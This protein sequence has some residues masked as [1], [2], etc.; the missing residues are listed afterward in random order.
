[1]KKIFVDAIKLGCDILHPKENLIESYSLTKPIKRNKKNVPL[2]MVV[3]P[4]RYYKNILK[5]TCL[6][7]INKTLKYKCLELKEYN[8]VL[9][10]SKHVEEFWNHYNIQIKHRIEH[11]I[12]NTSTDIVFIKKAHYTLKTVEDKI[13]HKYRGI[14]NKEVIE[15]AEN[16]EISTEIDTDIE[17]EKT[18]IYHKISEDI[19]QQNNQ[20]NIKSL[21]STRIREARLS[22]YLNDRNKNKV[23]EERSFKLTNDDLPYK[24]FKEWNK[25]Q[26]SPINYEKLLLEMQPTIVYKKR[27]EDHKNNKEINDNK[28]IPRSPIKIKISIPTVRK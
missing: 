3:K 22:D 9:L 12:D 10:T 16:L 7:T 1:M 23:I 4:L 17:L 15:L 26:K 28:N 2:K 18:Q 19:I 24:D 21:K 14:E 11:K 20:V 25:R 8:N 27:I 5:S 13:I 6:L